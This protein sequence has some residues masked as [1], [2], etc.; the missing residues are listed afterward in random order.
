M[1][2]A[3]AIA[4]E[5]SSCR[6]AIGRIGEAGLTAGG[7]QRVAGTGLTLWFVENF[8]SAE[9]CAFLIGQI[10]ANRI[11]SITLA[12]TPE[13][14]HRTSESG[15]LDRWDPRVQAIDGAICTL[16]GLD[17]RQGETLQG[18]RYGPGQ[19]FRSHHDWFHTDQPYWPQQ[20]RTGG[21]RTWTAMI[22]LNQPEA[23]GQTHFGAAGLTVTPRPGMLVA[24]N[25][26][27]EDG[28]PNIYAAHEGCD[29]TA[30]TKYVVTKW[31]RE[32]NWV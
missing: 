13:L 3:A 6:A 23:G 28:A 29:V 32:G 4:R 2:S 9:D 7:A 26:M 18:Q 5:T 15:N 1:R 31:F 12:T 10:E 22:Y 17:E 19:F 24:W 8:L 27:G 11:P 30:G 21:Q 20:A 14:D 16:L 25:N